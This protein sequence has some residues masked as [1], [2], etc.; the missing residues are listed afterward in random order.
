MPVPSSPPEPIPTSYQTSSRT[1]LLYRMQ[2]NF[3]LTHPKLQRSDADGGHPRPSRH[4]EV[5]IRSLQEQYGA[6]KSSIRTMCSNLRRN[7]HSLFRYHS[8]FGTSSRTRLLYRM[9]INFPPTHPPTHPIL[10]RSDAD[11]LGGTRVHHGI[12]KFQFYLD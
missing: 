12:L 2:I 11:A 4:P 10:Q 9:Q 5:P 1:H 8:L 7:T 3:P 6:F